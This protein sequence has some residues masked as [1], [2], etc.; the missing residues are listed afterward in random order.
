MDDCLRQEQ[1]ALLVQRE[2]IIRKIKKRKRMRRAT[3][4]RRR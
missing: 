2:G 3:M 4:R 1:V